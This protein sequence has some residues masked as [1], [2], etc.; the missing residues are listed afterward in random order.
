GGTP[1]WAQRLGDEGSNPSGLGGPHVA[2]DVGGNVYLTG[3]F[4][5]AASFGGATLTSVGATDVFV[6][7]LD[8][9]GNFLWAQ[10]MGDN[11]SGNFGA[12]YGAN[13]AVDSS[14]NVFTTGHFSSR[15]I[16]VSRYDS[17]GSLVWLKTMAGTA[18][19]GWGYGIAVDGDGN[20]Y[21]TGQY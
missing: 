3:T 17:N 21:T 7:K 5:G 1:L 4:A 9:A 10:Q 13:L 12:E 15:G 2:L 14:G 18:G 19:S 11:D 20:S 16:F 8:V 6:A